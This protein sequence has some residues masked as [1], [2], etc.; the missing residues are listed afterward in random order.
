MKIEEYQQILEITAGQSITS[1]KYVPKKSQLSLK[2][3][4]VGGRLMGIAKLESKK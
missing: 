1:G 4:C 2:Q 3:E